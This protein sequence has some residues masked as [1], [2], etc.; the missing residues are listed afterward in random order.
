MANMGLIHTGD[1]LDVVRN[2]IALFSGTS[3]SC[4]G[5]G[6][7]HN[8]DL[9]QQISSVGGG[10]YYIVNNLENVATVFGDVLGS[11]MSC[12][13]QQVRVVLPPGTEVKTRYSINKLDNGMEVVIGDLPAGMEGVVLAKIPSHTAVS[14]KGYNLQ[15]HCNI[16]L[17]TTVLTSGDEILQTS[18][19]A[20]YLRFE[21]LAI[22]DKS[23]NLILRRSNDS[24]VNA[25]IQVITE[26]IAKITEYRQGHEHSLWNVLIDEL[27]NCKTTLENRHTARHDATQH[28]TQHGACLG[29][30]RGIASSSAE[31]EDNAPG[32]PVSSVP[33]AP[34]FSNSVQRS[35][36]SQLQTHVTP[37]VARQRTQDPGALRPINENTSWPP[38]PPMVFGGFVRQTA[39]PLDDPIYNASQ[40]SLQ[41]SQSDSD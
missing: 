41:S 20:H 5:Y 8:V 37:I 36:S 32:S 15:T 25:H 40:V 11:L 31:E 3:I 19:E 18:G 17:N 9:L 24:E 10:S 33:L 27:N 13:A 29:M 26:C 21:V 34:V 2:T 38:M 6:T 16:E 39:C 23:K 22:L 7:D 14:L 35:I 4:V 12:I 28:M 30:L 1:I